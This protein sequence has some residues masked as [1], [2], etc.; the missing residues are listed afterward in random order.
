MRWSRRVEGSCAS[1][2]RALDGWLDSRGIEP[3]PASI[4]EHLPVCSDCRRH[5]TEWN[6]IELSLRAARDE[7][8][9]TAEVERLVGK[10]F[11]ISATRRLRRPGWW[12]RPPITAFA[13]V[14]AIVVI[15]LLTW[16]VWP[17]RTPQT[18]ARGGTAGSNLGLGEPSNL[19]PD[20]PVAATR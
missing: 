12:M 18:I 13:I 7:W 19:R 17:I 4:A 3:L 10:G 9:S 16:F 5:V 15:G 1:V 2:R 11:C 8:P 6:A 20:L 14:T